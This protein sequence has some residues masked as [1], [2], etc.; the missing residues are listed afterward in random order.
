MEA[1][2]IDEVINQ[3]DHI[4][5]V[6]KDNESSIGY[7]AALY[8][9]V[10]KTIRDKLK[11]DYF[12]DA[13]RMEKLDVIFANR[14]IS[15]YNNFTQGKPTTKSWELAFNASK[16]KNLI[17]LQHLLV[18]MNA[19]INL[20]L[21][22]AAAEISDEDTIQNLES[23]FNKINDVLGGLINEV[24]KDLSQIWP[25]LLV[26]LKFFKK[27]DDFL[28]NFSMNIARDEAWKFANQLVY[29]SDNSNLDDLISVRDEQVAKLGTYT[30]KPGILERI[31][32]RIIRFGEKGSI[33]D[34][35]E[36]LEN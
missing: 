7:F 28:I 8:N 13:T 1:T 34:K 4:I 25:K 19:H 35:I 3:L 26:I 24:E 27:V 31:I 14:F 12:E 22:I 30:V 23:D 32:F 5:Q 29:R 16:Q 11:E 21:G 6:S 9:K 17:V 20:D 33:S 15:A 2:K 18:G 10:T 36:A